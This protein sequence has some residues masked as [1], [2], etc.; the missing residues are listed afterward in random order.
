MTW[1]LNIVGAL[2]VL[3][4]LRDIFR[5]LWHPSGFGSLCRAAFDLVW[6]VTRRW[7]TELAGPLGL[8]TVVVTWSAMIVGGWTLIYLPHMPDG[9]YFGGPPDPGDSSDLVASIYLSLVA[10]A[11]LGFGDIVPAYPALR[12]VVPLQ[13]L[14]GFVLFTAAISWILQVYPALV[15]R[16]GLAE[17]L[18]LLADNDTTSYVGT[19]DPSTVTQLLQS[20][21]E[22]ILAVRMELLQYGET[23]YFAEKDPGISLAANLPY[24]LDLARVGKESGSID[25]RHAAHVLDGAITSTAAS[26]DAFV[27]GESTAQLLDGFAA[28]HRHPPVRG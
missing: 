11:T 16:R 17:R 13:A 28:D 4:A 14:V 10:V 22:E 5:T 3:A 9:F 27:G 26:L 7:S 8:L 24:A 1:F 25:V 19:G 20:L 21:T 2:L 12:L 18:S 15:R 6:K 23:Y